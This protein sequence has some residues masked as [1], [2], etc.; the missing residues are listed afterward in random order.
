ME[1]FKKYMGILE[2][3]LNA[4]GIAFLVVSIVMAVLAV[5]GFIDFENVEIGEVETT[6]EFGILK[7]E[8]SESVMADQEKANDLLAWS[9]L[10]L[11]LLFMISY[12]L[13]KVLHQ[14]VA[15]M[16]DGEI[17]HPAVAKG[18]RNLAIY[19]AVGGF[20]SEVLY[21]V[22]SYM[23]IAAYDITALFN[24][25]VVKDYFFKF[26]LN[27]NFIVYAAVIYLLSYVF[28]YGAELQTQVDETL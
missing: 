19:V 13:V 2:K 24:S 5:I 25:E 17:F 7:L 10:N 11:A 27:G 18:I 9:A 12:I 20:L 28:K 15:R 21:S 22:G 6:L 26:E 16:K 8:V 3:G 23:T 4:I 14:L 1:K